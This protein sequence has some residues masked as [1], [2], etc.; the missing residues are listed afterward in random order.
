MNV[1][2]HPCAQ[3]TV[4]AHSATELLTKGHSISHTAFKH[5]HT[6][7]LRGICAFTRIVYNEPAFSIALAV[8]RHGL[9][10]VI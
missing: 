9:F 2:P 3:S 7:M 4:C 1:T 5:D 10:A 8:C 6:L